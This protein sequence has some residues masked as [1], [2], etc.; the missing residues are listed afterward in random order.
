MLML[1]RPRDLALLVG[2][3]RHVMELVLLLVSLPVLFGVDVVQH[4]S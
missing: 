1:T 3:V 2:R 4:G